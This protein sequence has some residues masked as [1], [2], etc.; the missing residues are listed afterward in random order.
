[1]GTVVVNYVFTPVHHPSHLSSFNS[2]EKCLLYHLPLG[3]ISRI[4]TFTLS[5]STLTF[6][7]PSLPGLLVPNFF[8]ECFHRNPVVYPLSYYF[9]VTCTWTSFSFFFMLFNNSFCLKRRTRSLTHLSCRHPAFSIFLLL[10]L[11]LFRFFLLGTVLVT[12][13][14]EKQVYF[15]RLDKAKVE[16]SNFLNALSTSFIVFPM[17]AKEE[18]MGVMVVFFVCPIDNLRSV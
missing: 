10:F 17:L 8:C 12:N 5:L 4:L 3:P 6:T 1:M 16:F 18:E 2:Q 15:S 9:I 11:F 13:F 14:E 7:L